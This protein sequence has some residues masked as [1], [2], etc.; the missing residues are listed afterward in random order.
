MRA[1]KETRDDLHCFPVGD[2]GGPHS[3][4]VQPR[5]PLCSSES[6][7]WTIPSCQAHPQLWHPA[8]GRVTRKVCTRQETTELVNCL[9]PSQEPSQPNPTS[10]CCSPRVLPAWKL[11]KQQIEQRADDMAI[12]LATLETP[13]KQQELPKPMLYSI[14]SYFGIIVLTAINRAH[15]RS[16][17]S[18]GQPC[19]TLNWQHQSRSLHSVQLLYFIPDF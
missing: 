18:T 16:R 14:S 17:Q 12:K 10:K 15:E 13:G 8:H 11:T 9:L 4:Q 6:S 19:S 1:G 7:L 2:N 3:L 5:K